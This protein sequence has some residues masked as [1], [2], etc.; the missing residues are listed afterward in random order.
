MESAKLEVKFGDWIQAG[1]NLWKDNLGV[2]IVATLIAFLL[3][4]ITFGILAGPMM[5]GLTVIALAL[6]DKKEPKPQSG[7][8]FKGF[9][10]FAQSF[11]FLLVWGLLLFVVCGVLI[12][13]PCIGQLLMLAVEVVV[14]PLLMFALFLIVDK[15]MAFW[16]AS[17]ESI[18]IAKANFFPLLALCL[19][20]GAIGSVG[21]IACGV[22]IIVTAPIA[23]CILAVAYREITAAGPAPAPTNPTT[24]V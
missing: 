16:P 2:L 9:Q 17:L 19:I 10:F 3:S 15:Q 7:D 20:A 13:I 18:N 24:P 5:A 11:L 14:G 8:V 23:T 6:V 4:G 22:G 1:F 21:I 12:L